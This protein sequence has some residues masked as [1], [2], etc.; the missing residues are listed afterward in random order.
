MRSDK[1]ESRHSLKEQRDFSSAAPSG[2]AGFELF[3]TVC[4]GALIGYFVDQWLGTLPWC[5]V[6]GLITGGIAAFSSL[7]RRG[8]QQAETAGKN[9]EPIENIETNPTVSVTKEDGRL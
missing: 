5:M 6:A 3:G 8:E 4:A 1:K 7:I 2:N 9:I